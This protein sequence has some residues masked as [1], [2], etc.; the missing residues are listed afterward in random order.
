MEKHLPPAAVKGFFS[1]KCSNT[2]SE[3]ESSHCSSAALANRR[4]LSH[5]MAFY[6]YFL[7]LCRPV[8]IGTRFCHAHSLTD[9][10]V[11]ALHGRA[12][13]ISCCAGGFHVHL[14]A[15][16][17]KQENMHSHVQGSLGLVPGCKN[18][19]QSVASLDGNPK[20]TI[21]RTRPPVSASVSKF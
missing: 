4:I 21:S 12:A 11:E 7:F 18:R 16:V 10:S 15:W 19:F 17:T 13:Y 2:D 5:R 9:V 3:T 14:R 8:R 20:Q 1:C 6:F